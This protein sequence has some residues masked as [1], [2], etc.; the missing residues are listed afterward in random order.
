MEARKGNGLGLIQ[1]QA[2]ILL[3]YISWLISANNCV[4]ISHVLRAVIGGQTARNDE[5][6]ALWFDCVSKP[7]KVHKCMRL[8]VCT[9]A[10]H[11]LQLLQKRS[12]G[13]VLQD[14]I[15]H[16]RKTSRIKSLDHIKVL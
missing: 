15:G 16:S 2:F 7:K 10:M 13:P 12:A 3:C 14:C 11:L 5:D 6:Q 1:E 9:S 4:M 8:C